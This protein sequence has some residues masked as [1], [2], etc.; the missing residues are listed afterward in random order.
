[1]KRSLCLHCASNVQTVIVHVRV[2]PRPLPV[3]LQRCC[4][5]LW[6]HNP[7]LYN[8]YSALGLKSNGRIPNIFFCVTFDRARMCPPPPTLFVCVCF[9]GIVQTHIKAEGGGGD[10]CC[11]HAA[12]FERNPLICAPSA[13]EHRLPHFS[14]SSALFWSSIPQIRRLNCDDMLFFCV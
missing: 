14:S 3:T 12:R 4:C 1:M 5:V 10:N 13:R 2:T 9:L 11:F 8:I 7:G 6:L